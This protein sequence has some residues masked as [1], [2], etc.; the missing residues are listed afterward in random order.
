MHGQRL[1]SGMALGITFATAP[2]AASEIY[3]WIG[4]DGVT[5]YS[6]SA[7]ASESRT[8]ETVEFPDVEPPSA[9][10]PGYREALDVAK[11]I[12]AGRLERERLR[13]ERQK[14]RQ[15]QAQAAARDQREA[16]EGPRYYPVYPYYR[17]Y[18]RRHPRH[19][20]GPVP[21]REPRYD[22][23]P[24]RDIPARMPGMTNR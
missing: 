19:G 22:Y 14:L 10:A 6:E 7:P 1:L 17:Q 2:V 8:V 24:R 12:E 4:T 15:E 3:K 20:P 21:Y 16:A 18:P 13:L 9:A 23:P 5:H 11:D